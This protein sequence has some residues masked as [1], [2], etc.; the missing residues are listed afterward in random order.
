MRWQYRLCAGADKKLSTV[1]TEATREREASKKAIAQA[2]DSG[3]QLLNANIS[4]ML[5]S[6]LST[7]KSLFAHSCACQCAEARICGM[8]YVRYQNKI[9]EERTIQRFWIHAMDAKI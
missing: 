3:L 8:E 7:A 4:D 2:V 5:V 1:Q 9:R 6:D